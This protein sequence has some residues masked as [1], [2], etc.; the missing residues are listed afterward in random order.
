MYYYM[1][2]GFAKT[3]IFFF[4]KL[5]E[6]YASMRFQTETKRKKEKTV[7]VDQGNTHLDYSTLAHIYYWNNLITC[8]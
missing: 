8:N 4:Q 6:G 3:G 5:N 7:P 2:I 1:S